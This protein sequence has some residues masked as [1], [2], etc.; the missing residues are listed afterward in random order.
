VSRLVQPPI[1]F[2]LLHVKPAFKCLT[3][4][5]YPSHTHAQHSRHAAT[6]QKT[7]CSEFFEAWRFLEQV[8]QHSQNA[9]LVEVINYILTPHPGE[10]KTIEEL[11]HAW[12][13]PYRGLRSFEK[14]Q[15][16]LSSSFISYLCISVITSLHARARAQFFCEGLTFV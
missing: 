6:I 3:R 15:Q 13:T 11:G 12:T 9:V 1:L 4:T 10:L 14:I 7:N 16:C 8:A 2:L 5:L